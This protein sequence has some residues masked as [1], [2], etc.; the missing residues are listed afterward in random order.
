MKM[1]VKNWG[2]FQH[3]KDRSPAW[4]KLHRHI[5]DDYDFQ[6]L[7]VAS[8]A[9]A[10]MLW[11][12][13]S[14]YEDGEI[15]ASAKKLAFRLRISEKELL[16]ALNPLIDAG[17]FIVEQDASEA[18]AACLP[19]EEEE[20]EKRERREE[21]TS[22]AGALDL[23]APAPAKPDPVQQVFDHW[24]TTLK[25]P[26]AKLDDK[27]RKL[28]RKALSLGYKPDDLMHAIT[29]CSLSPFHMGENDNGRRYDGLDLILRDAS[30][31]DQFI[32]FY[33]D[34]PR[35]ATK[36]ASRMNAIGVDD[37]I[38]EGFGDGV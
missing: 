16:D 28:I 21:D 27:R 38:P 11:L 19:R 29:G 6:C 8:R 25:H 12:L 37:Q 35:A 22:N 24:R 31:I 18:L 7:P 10:P 33:N 30:K 13:A 17:F 2:E 32:G 14:E 4:I 1:R 36:G 9:L 3:Y 20:K 15:D 26:H 5:L 34:P 23:D